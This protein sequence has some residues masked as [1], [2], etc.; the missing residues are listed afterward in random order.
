MVGLTGASACGDKG[1]GSACCLPQSQLTP[2]VD[3]LH[4]HCLSLFQALLASDGIMMQH[5]S[6]SN[7]LPVISLR[8]DSCC[9]L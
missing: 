2:S 8:R 4:S 1:V 7:C 3:A 9:L 5:A 6:I